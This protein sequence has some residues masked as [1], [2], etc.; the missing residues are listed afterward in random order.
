ML[1][2]KKVPKKWKISKCQNF[3][4][5]K[6]AYFLYERLASSSISSFA[7]KSAIFVKRLLLLV[8][9]VSSNS[10]APSN[11]NPHSSPLVTTI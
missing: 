6:K 8:S 1:T 10:T 3:K 2:A 11:Q 7:S 4:I 5:V 9:A